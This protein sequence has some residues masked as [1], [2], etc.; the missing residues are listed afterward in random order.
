MA[1]EKKNGK[2]GSIFFGFQ[3]F[4]N[5]LTDH[6]SFVR[7]RQLFKRRFLVLSEGRGGTFF[8]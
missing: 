3:Y 5:S 7:T 8:V 2:L 1:D 6:V 4:S